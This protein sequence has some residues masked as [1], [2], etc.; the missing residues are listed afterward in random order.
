ME[1]PPTN[2]M[3]PNQPSFVF[4]DIMQRQMVS[5]AGSKTKYF[6]SLEEDKNTV[7]VP[8]TGTS[9]LQDPRG[10]SNIDCMQHFSMFVAITS[11]RYDRVVARDVP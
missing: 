5:F 3:E 11:Q 8:G 9:A 4:F 6:W 10:A 1:S 7:P 2:L